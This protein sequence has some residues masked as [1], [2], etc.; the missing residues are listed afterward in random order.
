MGSKHY[1]L[2][3][4]QIN[5]FAGV[6]FQDPGLSAKDLRFAVDSLRE[7]HQTHRFFLTLITDSMDALRNKL[8]R[9]ERFRATDSTLSETICGYHLEGP[10][11][12]S[13]P[14]FSGAH[15]P[16]LMV[17]PD[18]K[19]LESLWE[20]AMGNLRLITI[21]PERP[22]SDEV[23]SRA[24]ELGIAMSLGH[25]DATDEQI[26]RAIAAGACFCT[27]LGNGAPVI[28]HRHDNIIQRLL[29]R[30][31]LTAFFI[32]DGLHVPPGVLRSYFRVKPDGKAFFTT[33]CMAAA[34]APAG[35]YRLAHNE[36]E[37]GQDRVVRVPGQPN[38]AGS[39]LAPNEGV[40]NIRQW[41][42]LTESRARALFGAAA[43]AQFGISVPEI[44]TNSLC[45]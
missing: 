45:K 38:F 16:A 39:S 18:V 20:A 14:G 34:G 43:A 44:P 24:S 28:L 35:R 36:V 37:V 2:F 11:L 5:G 21:A 4:C 33:D 8:G 10:W 17:E 3:D 31:E 9:I 32:A 13:K 29:A 7:R 41:L 19:G 40:K 23:I 25:T 30:D 22:G 42:D 12:S 15:D 6:D 1:S 26:D 27:H